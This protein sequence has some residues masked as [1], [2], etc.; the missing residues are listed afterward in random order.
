MF[1]QAIIHYPAD[2]KALEQISKEMANFRCSETIKYIESL[3]LN[4]KQI[5]T[6]YAVLKEEMVETGR[7]VPNQMRTPILME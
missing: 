2:E 1:N 3:K 5:E 6:L 7:K 4:D